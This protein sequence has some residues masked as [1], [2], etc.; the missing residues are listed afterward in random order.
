V[1]GSTGELG[2]LVVRELLKGV[3]ASS[4]VA[5][6]RSVDRL[7]KPPQEIARRN[8]GFIPKK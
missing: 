7:N 4:I 8:G 1:T 5:C 6:V 3:S 2:R